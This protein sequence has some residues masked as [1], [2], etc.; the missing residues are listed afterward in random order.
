MPFK[1]IALMGYIS[2]QPG[3]RVDVVSGEVHQWL[4]RL[5][6]RCSLEL[7]YH[8]MDTLKFMRNGS[9]HSSL[10][11]FKTKS[12]EVLTW[13]PWYFSLRWHMHINLANFNTCWHMQVPVCM[14]VVNSNVNVWQK[15]QNGAVNRTPFT[16]WHK[17]LIGYYVTKKKNSAFCMKFNTFKMYFTH[18]VF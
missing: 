5:T 18:F 4:A 6:S 12:R 13:N 17:V 16:K 9:I 1:T 2:S 14:Q 10:W 8:R 11:C 15:F 3:Q 7:S